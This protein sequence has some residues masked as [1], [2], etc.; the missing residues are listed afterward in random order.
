[1]NIYSVY[2]TLN[3]NHMNTQEYVMYGG[4]FNPPHQDHTGII[5]TLLANVAEKVIIIPTGKREDKDY[6]SVS[7]EVRED[8][9]RLATE[10]FGKNIIIDTTFLY[11]D[12]A[13]TTINQARYLE[14]KYKK[15]IPQVF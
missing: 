4:A 14:E 1:M 10:D 2:L 3:I 15:E 5:A 6:S 11:G 7:N 13:T 8:M 9:I 12:M